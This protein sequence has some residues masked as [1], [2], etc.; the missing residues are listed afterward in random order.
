MKMNVVSEHLN[1]IVVL[2]PKVFDD[3]RGFFLEAFRADEFADLGLPTRFVQD[4]H[5][6]SVVGVLRGV[7]FGERRSAFRSGFPGEHGRV[8]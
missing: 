8:Y 1:G 4:N 2:Q 3:D 7:D 5:S 6:G